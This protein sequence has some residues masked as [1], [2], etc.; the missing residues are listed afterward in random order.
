MTCQAL[1]PLL[2]CAL[3]ESGITRAE[4]RDRGGVGGAHRR[5]PAN[6][7]RLLAAISEA[8]L[9]NSSVCSEFPARTMESY[10]EGRRNLDGATRALL[11][12]IDRERKAASRGY[13]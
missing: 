9:R 1:L 2:V 8:R 10:E 5:S 6:A 13:A 11:R 12:I 4:W 3:H 7:R